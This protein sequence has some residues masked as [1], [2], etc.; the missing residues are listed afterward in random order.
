MSN[1]SKKGEKMP[2]HSGKSDFAQGVRNFIDLGWEE[3]QALREYRKKREKKRRETI[4]KRRR[5]GLPVER[6]EER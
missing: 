2:P 3:R 4:K 1:T 6:L 5:A